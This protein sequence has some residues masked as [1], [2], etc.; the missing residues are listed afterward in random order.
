MK[1]IHVD[2]VTTVIGLIVLAGAITLILAWLNPV[3]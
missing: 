2:A 1:R 3:R